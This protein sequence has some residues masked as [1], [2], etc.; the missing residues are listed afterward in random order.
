MTYQQ[1]LYAEHSLTPGTRVIR[2][3][4]TRDGKPFSRLYLYETGA[5]FA[6][7]ELDEWFRSWEK[8]DGKEEVSCDSGD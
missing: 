5:A 7:G 8:W 3:T 1:R 2:L 6:E 4:G